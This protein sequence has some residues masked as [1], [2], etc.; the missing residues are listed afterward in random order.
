MRN[1]HEALD[2]LEVLLAEIRDAID[3][4]LRLVEQTKSKVAAGEVDD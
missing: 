3:E 4:G 2:E 1:S